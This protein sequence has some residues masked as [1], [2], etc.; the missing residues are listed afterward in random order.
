MILREMGHED[1]VATSG[2]AALE[3]MGGSQ[4]QVV[5]SDISM[6]RMSGYDLARALREQHGRDGLVLVAMTGYGQ[7]EDRDRA[8]EAGFDF[9]LVKPAD[10][11]VLQAVLASLAGG[12]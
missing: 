2:E 6:P 4:P 10:V 12:A 1:E 5:F 8:L 7:P 11:P 3:L 9:H